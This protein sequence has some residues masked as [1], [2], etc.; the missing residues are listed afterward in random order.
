MKGLKTWGLMQW[1]YCMKIA[2][3][4]SNQPIYIQNSILKPFKRRLFYQSNAW[5][6]RFIIYLRQ[7]GIKCDLVEMDKNDW[8]QKLKPYDLVIWKPQFMGV[9]SSQNFKEK[10]FFIQYF[11]K[12]RVYPNY[13]TVWH[14][15]S[16]IAQSYIFRYQKIRTPE[17]FVSFDYNE[18]MHHAIRLNYPVVVKES[19]GASSSGV[20]LVKSCRNLMRYINSRFLWENLLSRK[21][22]SRIFDRFGHLYTQR[23]LRGNSCDLRITIIGD[24]YAFGFWRKNRNNDFRASGSGRI[25]YES[26]LPKDIISYCARISKMNH[27]DSMAY[28]ILF[29]KDKFY[30]VEM[31]YGYNDRAVYNCRGYYVLDEKCEI[32]DFVE[33]HYWPQQLWVRWLLDN[34]QDCSKLARK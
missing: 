1:G 16:K 29:R 21:L 20:S 27:F 28:D 18:A 25:D 2:V 6:Y 4:I 15:D 26:R 3:G 13:E 10:I 19:S 23:F 22:S 34:M 9:R 30:I 33:G 7:E 12:K 8:I 17:T 14:F 31:S 24:R 32:S 5:A 11:M